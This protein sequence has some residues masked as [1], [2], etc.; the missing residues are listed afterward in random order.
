MN[1]LEREYGTGDAEAHLCAFPYGRAHY[2]LAVQK[3]AVTGVKIFYPPLAVLIR[4]FDVLATDI[5]VLNADFALIGA[6]DAERRS[7]FTFN[8][9]FN[10]A[11]GD[12][13]D[14]G[15]RLIFH[16]GKFILA[17]LLVGVLFDGG[18]FARGRWRG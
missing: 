13:K 15:L 9:R 4:D 14:W 18:G 12:M 17:E 2:F 11:N 7:E 16:D 3:D 6:A 1:Y 5:F 10:V 8:G